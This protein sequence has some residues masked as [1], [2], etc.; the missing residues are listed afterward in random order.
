MTTENE[1]KAAESSFD[2]LQKYIRDYFAQRQIDPNQLPDI[3]VKHIYTGAMGNVWGTIITGAFLVFFGNYIGMTPFEW[4][5]MGAIG[6]WVL[7]T[8]L[9]A[10]AITQRM[11]HRKFLWF[12]CALADRGL[13]FV[14]ILL[15]LLLWHLGWTHAGLVLILA[16]S[17]ATCLGAMANPPWLSWLA[18][19]IPEKQQGTFWGRRLMWIS[20][21][22]VATLIPAAIFIDKAPEPWKIRATLLVFLVGTLIGLSDIVI[23]GTIP[24]P[25]IATPKERDFFKQLMEALRDKG[26]RPWL[27][28]VFCWQFSLMLGATLLLIYIM[29]D[30]GMSRNMLGVTIATTVAYLCGSILSAKHSGALV[31]RWGAKRVMFWGYLFW[32]LLPISWLFLTPTN[33]GWIIGGVNVVA[34]VFLTGGTNAS[35]KIQTR[36]PPDDRRLM[37]IAVSNSTNYIASGL[38]ALTAGFIVKWLE[39]WHWSIGE[40]S[41]GR[42]DCI[43]VLSLVLRVATVLFLLRSIRESSDQAS[44]RTSLLR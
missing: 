7:L 42:Y 43:G 34:G 21:A 19:I 31:D 24:E 3:M 2:A 13:R 17:V 44:D 30:L 26:F 35:L 5:V 1:L 20:L 22:V 18:D 4:G 9:V 37:Y 11:G 36:F 10:A 40:H 12:V 23:H 6:T 25:A 38:A 16:I 39:G 14:G 27:T 29:D 28:F 32:A 41:F 8:E 33:V 15:A